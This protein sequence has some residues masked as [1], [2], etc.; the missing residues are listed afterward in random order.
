MIDGIAPFVLVLQII[1][2]LRNLLQLL[3]FDDLIDLFS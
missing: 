1:Q 3:N 2:F